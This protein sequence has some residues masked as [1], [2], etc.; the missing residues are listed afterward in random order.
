MGGPACALHDAGNR[1]ARVA[2]RDRSPKPTELSATARNCM[3]A[4][5]PLLHPDSR[6]RPGDTTTP[7]SP[8]CGT[9]S[10]PALKDS[11]AERK[12]SVFFSG[13]DPDVTQKAMQRSQEISD[14]RLSLRLKLWRTRARPGTRRLRVGV[15]WSRAH[16]PAFQRSAW[17]A[18]KRGHPT[19]RAVLDRRPITRGRAARGWFEPPP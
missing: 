16:A 13:R 18:S 19:L 8:S 5:S 6:T 4:L 17:A 15:G 7:K 14:C 2:K 12:I 1:R 10:R 3:S 9:R 11:N